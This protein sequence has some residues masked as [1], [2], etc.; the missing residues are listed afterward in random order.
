MTGLASEAAAMSLG[1]MMAVTVMQLE[2]A[3]D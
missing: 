3:Q 2:L 1:Q